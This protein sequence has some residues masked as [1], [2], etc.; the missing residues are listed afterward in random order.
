MVARRPSSHGLDSDENLITARR[1]M[2]IERCAKPLSRRSR[3]YT[4]LRP[5]ASLTFIWVSTDAISSG[6]SYRQQKLS[7]GSFPQNPGV[8]RAGSRRRESL[9]CVRASWSSS[10]DIFSK[11]RRH[12]TQRYESARLYAVREP[13]R[14]RVYT[15]LGDGV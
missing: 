13:K 5:C 3:R 14:A 1:N 6:S 10:S 7:T 2:L 8:S 15:N 9:C 11:K 12:R 4:L